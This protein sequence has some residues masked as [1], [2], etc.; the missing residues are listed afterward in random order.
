MLLRNCLLP[1]TV[2]I[3][4]SYWVYWGVDTDYWVAV[5]SLRVSD[6]LVETAYE[7]AVV[8]TWIARDNPQVDPQ[9]FHQL[10]SSSRH[11]LG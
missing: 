5:V 9:L 6:I 8:D 4:P 3:V 11:P 1:C 7:D 2:D 10:H